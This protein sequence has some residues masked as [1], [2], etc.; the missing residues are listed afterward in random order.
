MS[1]IKKLFHILIDNFDKSVTT[2]ADGNA[3]I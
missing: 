3:Q 2:F 1:S